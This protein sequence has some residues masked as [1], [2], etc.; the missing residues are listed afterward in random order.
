M[1]DLPFYVASSDLFI[2]NI[3]FSETEVQISYL[4][5]RKQLIGLGSMEVLMVQLD[6]NERWQETYI[7]LQETLKD[8]VDDV[9]VFQRTEGKTLKSAEIKTPSE[10]MA[11]TRAEARARAF[12][13]G[14]EE[15]PSPDAG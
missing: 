3:Q 15:P 7:A 4:Q 11:E 6:L 14:E 2:T 12:L 13:L 5:N 10:R 9:L 1:I 8:F